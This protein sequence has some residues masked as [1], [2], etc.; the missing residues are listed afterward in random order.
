[1]QRI[2][3]RWPTR[4][5]KTSKLTPHLWG[6]VRLCVF[7]LTVLLTLP[8]DA[9]ARTLYV[10]AD[11]SEAFTSIQVACDSA[12]AGDTVLVRDGEY[13]EGSTIEVDSA[14]FLRAEHNGRCVVFLWQAEVGLMLLGSAR[15]EGFSLRGSTLP[16]YQSLVGIYGGPAIIDNCEF[17]PQELDGDALAIASR[18]HPPLIRHCHFGPL[19]GGG[20]VGLVDTTDVWMPHNY[21]GTT[22]TLAIHRGIHDG[23][24]GGWW[25][26]VTVSPVA[27]S[28]QWLPV[29]DDRRQARNT[30]ADLLV[31]PEPTSGL[32]TLLVSGAPSGGDIVV[33][34]VL[35]REV[36]RYSVSSL[37]GPSGVNLGHLSSGAYFLSVTSASANWS[38]PIHVI[39]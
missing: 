15:L 34:D 22:D 10:A 18:G 24:D 6:W 32:I 35:G 25:G 3:S 29:E 37:V 16:P 2:S 11:S 7:T 4:K 9:E 36:Q 14:V 13:W 17:M 27:D 28:F 26:Y 5:P 33:F 20:S 8:G 21:W 23:H 19:M 12:L 1:M 30:I 38:K 39:K 31:Y